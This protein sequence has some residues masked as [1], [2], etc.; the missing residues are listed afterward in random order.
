MKTTVTFDIH[1]M[2]SVAGRCHLGERATF[3]EAEQ[4]ARWHAARR[5]IRVEIGK[6]TKT[7]KRLHNEQMAVVTRD[8]LG[9]LWTD[10]TW[11]GASL[12]EG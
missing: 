12:V 6:I 3:D 8:A 10:L 9:R 4:F 2:T 5:G 11:H 1:N 7:A